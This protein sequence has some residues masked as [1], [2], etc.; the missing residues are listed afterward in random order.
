MNTGNYIVSSCVISNQ[1]VK[2]NGR[3]LFEAEYTDVSGFLLSAY[4]LIGAKYPK[5][6]K[7]DNLAKLGWLAAEVLL[8]D[9]DAAKYQPTDISVILSNASSS[10]DAD[11]RYYD[12]V[13]EIASPALF[14][15]TLPNIVIGE[16]SIRHHF[17]GENAFFVFDRFNADFIANYVSDLLNNQQL[18]ACICGW[19][20]LLDNDYKAVLFLIEKEGETPFTTENINKIYSTANE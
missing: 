8:K 14:V 7:M 10:L 5:F 6:Y 13:Q 11:K 3:L 4:Q 20:E 17:K 9:F 16:I 19:V 12:S 2:H 1:A 18:Q 15:Y